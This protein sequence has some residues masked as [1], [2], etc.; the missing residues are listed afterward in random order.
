MI[1]QSFL[2][3]A[4]FFTYTLVLTKFYGVNA[5]AAPRYLLD[6]AAGNLLGR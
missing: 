2:Y 5:S 3:N 6:F 1:S 4:M